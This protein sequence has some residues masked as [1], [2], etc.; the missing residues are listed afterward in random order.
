METRPE[1]SLINESGATRGKS[2]QQ[3]TKAIGE[4]QREKFCICIF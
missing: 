2:L 1:K 4:K 3:Q